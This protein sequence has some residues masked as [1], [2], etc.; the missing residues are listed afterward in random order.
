[1]HARR[2][3]INTSSLVSPAVSLPN[4]NATSSRRA[5]ATASAA[6]ERAS[7][8]ACAS[9]RVRADTANASAVPR[10]ASPRS[11][12]TVARSSTSS[13][14]AER[15]RAS[16]SGKRLGRTRY[17]RESPIVFIA[18]AAAPMLPGWVGCESTMRMRESGLDAVI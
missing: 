10:S 4:R 1:M 13:A 16:G 3:H 12:Q 18:R 6:A 7:S 2:L 9:S 14:F 5:Q 17:S 8:G 15:A 11:S